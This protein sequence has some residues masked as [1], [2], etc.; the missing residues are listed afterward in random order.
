MPIRVIVTKDF[1]HMSAVAAGLVRKILAR[2]HQ[3]KREAVLGL[4]TGNT[5]TG[6]YKLL[7]KAANG[8]DF[9]A[10]RVRSFNL[11]EYIGIPG[12]NAQQ[13]VLHPE[14]YAYFM[15]QEFFSLLKR[16]FAETCVP[17]GA[18]I[19]QERFESELNRHPDDWVA[20]GQRAGK[21]IVI[22]GSARSEYLAWIRKD[23]QQKYDEKIRSFGGIDIQ[24]IGVGGEG[25]V[26]FHEA[27][28]PFKGSRVLIVQME[29]NTI[30]NAVADGHFATERDSPRFA[31]SMGAEL[32]YEARNVI[33]LAN[34]ERK[35]PPLA[36]SLLEGVS[37]DVPISYGQEYA[38]SGGNLVYVVDGVAGADLVQS[39][40]AL[41]AKDIELEDLR[42]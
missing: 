18:L 36:R 22:S 3:A 16:K 40:S 42:A 26:A 1:D 7:A 34:G 30:K 23:I 9:D 13:R 25:H 19:E 12:D 2:V 31:V 27:G 28:I 41:A 39:R 32:V 4:A 29:G 17:Y 37:A 33:L 11:D 5:P 8:G 24:I 14:S 15:I 6:L 10:A 21:S 35:R 38:R 20:E